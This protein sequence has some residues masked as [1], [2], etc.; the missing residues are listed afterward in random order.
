MGNDEL[1]SECVK[2]PRDRIIDTAQL[3]FRKHGIRGVGVDA[4]AEEAGTNKMTLYRHFGSKDELIAECLRDTASGV[5]PFW[6]DLEAAHPGDGMAQLH[7]WVRAVASYASMEGGGCDLL[8][9]AFELPEPDHPARLV[10]EAFK[11]E[12]RNRLAALCRAAGI[13]E[14]ERLADALGL[15][16]EGARVNRRTVGPDGASANF[17]T[18]AEAVIASFSAAAGAQAARD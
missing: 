3:L 10:V 16:L 11:H 1:V 18:I 2:R 4:I 8:T 13:V 17:V 6:R 12:Q 15:L 14:A 7:E 9:A 5:E